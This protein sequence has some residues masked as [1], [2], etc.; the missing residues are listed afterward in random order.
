MDY[1]EVVADKARI[2]VT[3][4]PIDGG[5]LTTGVYPQK[6]G[7]PQYLLDIHQCRTGF[8]PRG[9]AIDGNQRA[10][11][12]EREKIVSFQKIGIAVHIHY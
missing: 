1:F 4:A 5:P 6:G 9:Y 8:V 3:R 7:L 12:G 2:D 10:T 11:Q